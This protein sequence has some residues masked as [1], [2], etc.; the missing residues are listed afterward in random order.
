MSDSHEMTWFSGWG[1]V[2]DGRIKPDVCAPGCQ[3][4]GD[5]GIASTVEN[6]GYE[7]M[8]GSSMATPVISGVMALVYE[9]IQVV[10][11]ATVHPMPATLKALVINT[12]FDAGRPGPDFS[13]GFGEIRAEAAVST[14]REGNRIIASLIN[15]NDIIHYTL[16]VEAGADEL[17]LTLV[18]SDPVGEPLAAIELVNDIDIYLESPQGA[19]V[20]PWILN[21]AVPDAAAERGEDHLN[22]IEQI[23]V[24][25]PEPGTW[26]LRVA[27]TTIPFGPQSYSLVANHP[28]IPAFSA[29]EDSCEFP[30]ERIQSGSS[31]PN[32][33]LGTIT[34]SYLISQPGHKV[35]LP[36]YD[37]SGRLIR[38]LTDSPAAAGRYRVFWD[39]NDSSGDPVP[40][41]VYFY[42]AEL[43]GEKEKGGMIR[44]MVL[45]R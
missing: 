27:G 17:K 7:A 11:G 45:M 14:A 20:Y 37:I 30:G 34:V 35:Y 39:G 12:A 9:Q 42:R 41:G 22:P 13:Y 36:I 18:W 26:F 10:A 28:L 3:S 38:K 33:G 25:D 32:P 29:A 15:Q 31:F 19:L 1:P 23:V 8:C 24:T 40:A 43:A 5:H 2:D 6:G 4:G 44:R 21:P 16:D